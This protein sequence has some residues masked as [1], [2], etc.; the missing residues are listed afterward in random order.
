MSMPFKLMECTTIY[1]CLGA[2]IT[3]TAGIIIIMLPIKPQQAC[4]A[5]RSLLN[6][7]QPNSQPASAQI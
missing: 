4:A 6:T 3:F 2:A 7:A 5:S 1:S